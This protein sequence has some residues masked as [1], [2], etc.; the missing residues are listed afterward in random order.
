MTS[1]YGRTT[2]R[3][4]VETAA[5]AV[6]DDLMAWVGVDGIVAAMRTPAVLAQLDQHMA[7]VRDELGQWLDYAP[8]LAE[9]AR[10][11]HSTALA[12]GHVFPSPRQ[13]DWTYAPDYVLRLVAVCALADTSDC[14]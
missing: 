11:V 13:L 9:Y 5:R 3:T 1:E 8:A 7:A 2:H 12:E 4:A 14:L 6:L 10:V